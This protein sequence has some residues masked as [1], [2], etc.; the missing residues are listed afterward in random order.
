MTRLLGLTTYLM[1]STGRTARAGLAASVARRGLRLWHV[2]VLEAL[3]EAGPLA[4]GELAA[5]LDINPSDIVKVVDDLGGQ[6][7]LAC[8][9][10]ARDRRRINVSATRAGRALLAEL[11]EELAAVE[12]DVLAPLTD[13]ERAQLAALL[14]RLVSS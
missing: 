13:G 1:S 5:R 4:K 2:A 3:V 6:G 7:Y 11:T 8:T 9:R 14:S 10:S 12:E